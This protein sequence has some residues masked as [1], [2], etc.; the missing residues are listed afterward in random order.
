MEQLHRTNLAETGITALCPI[1]GML[2]VLI[3]VWAF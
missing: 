2:C 1:T 3:M